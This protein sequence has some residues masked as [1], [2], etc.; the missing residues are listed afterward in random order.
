MKFTIAH[1]LVL[2]V[3][4]ATPSTCRNK[5]AQGPAFRLTSDDIERDVAALDQAAADAGFVIKPA[6]YSYTAD[7][8]QKTSVRYYET[9]V[10]CCF[11]MV[12]SRWHDEAVL[13]VTVSDRDRGDRDPYDPADCAMYN[14]FRA[15]VA[16]KFEPERIFYEGAVCAALSLD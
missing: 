4:M 7:N 11:L 2:L 14:S 6:N 10:R 3:L 13:E 16:A 15:S 12:L 8:H 5:F 1:A 9:G